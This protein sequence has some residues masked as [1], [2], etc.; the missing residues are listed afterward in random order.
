[1]LRSSFQ[2]A[3]SP[4]PKSHAGTGLSFPFQRSSGRTPLFVPSR[5]GSQFRS[6]FDNLTAPYLSVMQLQYQIGYP[7]LRFPV[8]VPS[9]QA[10]APNSG[11]L[12]TCWDRPRPPAAAARS[13][14]GL[15]F[16]E[17]SRYLPG[18]PNYVKHMAFLAI[19][20]G[21]SC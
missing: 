12:R 2:A 4:R 1:M 13:S 17:G 21:S 15:P 19:F 8:R 10:R 14:V 6:S 5:H 9:I 16:P 18:P 20:R 7:I 3:R 11:R